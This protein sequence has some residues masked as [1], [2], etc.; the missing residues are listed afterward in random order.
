[1]SI[2]LHSLISNYLLFKYD[3]VTI[4]ET[5]KPEFPD[6]TICNM[7]GIYADR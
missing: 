4:S 5:K 3:E 7:D 1:M 6:V 2:Q